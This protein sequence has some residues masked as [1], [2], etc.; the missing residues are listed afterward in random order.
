MTRQ[1]SIRSFRGAS[2][3]LGI[4]VAIT[5]LASA[6]GRDDSGAA[7]G[8]DFDLSWNTIDCGG[9]TL[10]GGGS[11][12]L[13]GTIGQADASLTMTGGG[14]DG[15]ELTGGFWPGVDMQPI[16]P[17]PADIRP[18]GGDGT[19]NVQDLLG[20]I[21]SWGACPPPCAA[22]EADVAPPGGNCVVNVQDLLL[23][24]ANWGACP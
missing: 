1:H 5:A 24:I 2:A 4:A 8:Q 12:E 20:V 21:A 19:V 3:W 18:T 23:V 6:Q 7:A 15:F 22:C 11:F 16:D 10:S 13:G 17:C 14:P 9:E